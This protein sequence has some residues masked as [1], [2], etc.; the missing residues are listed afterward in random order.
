MLFYE[1]AESSV[2][3]AITYLKYSCIRDIITN[4]KFGE[5]GGLYGSNI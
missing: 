3:F 4:N 1:K 5:Q 2:L